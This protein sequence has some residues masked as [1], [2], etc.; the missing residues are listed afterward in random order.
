LCSKSNKVRNFQV[1]PAVEY[2]FVPNA[3]LVS[4][5]DST[6]VHFQWTGSDNNPNNNDGQGRAGT[7]RSNVVLI[8]KAVSC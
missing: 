4:T 1:Y 7:D 5:E 2:D 8:E 3:P 6:Y